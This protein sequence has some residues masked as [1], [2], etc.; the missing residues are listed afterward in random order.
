MNA[1]RF[2]PPVLALAGAVLLASCAT[3]GSP[4]T[5]EGD[6]PAP[7]AAGEQSPAVPVP[8]QV[9]DDDLRLPEEEF[10]KMPGEGEFRQT[11]PAAVGSPAPVIVRPPTEPPPL[12]KGAP[13]AGEIAP[14]AGR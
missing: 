8:P 11:G 12:P 5:S 9:A 13:P 6:A 14:P 2:F 3:P 4:E 7:A 1:P 10:F